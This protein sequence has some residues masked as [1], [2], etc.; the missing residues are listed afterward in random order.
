MLISNLLPKHQ[1]EP[2]GSF[3]IENT[4]NAISF[5][6]A[7]GI[8]LWMDVETLF[9]KLENSTLM[10]YTKVGQKAKWIQSAIQT[11]LWGAW[12]TLISTSLLCYCTHKTSVALLW[13]PKRLKLSAEPSPAHRPLCNWEAASICLQ[14]SLLM[15]ITR[16]LSLIQDKKF[17]LSNPKCFFSLWQG[18][19]SLFSIEKVA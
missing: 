7:L 18:I 10:L 12:A 11:S 3:T 16:A 4:F 5:R 1:S 6:S 14:H 8:C 19:Q 2:P 9:P 17:H 13:D 15:W